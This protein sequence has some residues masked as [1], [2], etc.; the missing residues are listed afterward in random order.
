MKS[1]EPSSHPHPKHYQQPSPS[2]CRATN[3]IEVKVALIM[4]AMS[5]ILF[6]TLLGF[7]TGFSII[8][9]RPNAAVGARPTTALAAKGEAKRKKELP[10][11]SWKMSWQR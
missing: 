2:D 7:T 11:P 1:E 3:I 9:S 10:E 4:H 8:T 6:L 5:T